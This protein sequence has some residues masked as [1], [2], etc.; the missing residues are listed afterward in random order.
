[1]KCWVAPRDVMP[2]ELYADAIVHAMDTAKV[3]VL[4][5]SRSAATSP[6]VLR[7]VERATSKRHPVIALRI[8]AAPLASLEYFLNTSQWLD[9]RKGD[10][11]Y[12]SPKLVDAVQRHLDHSASSALRAQSI[13]ADRS[14][15]GVRSVLRR[16]WIVSGVVAVLSLALAYFIVDGISSLAA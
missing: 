8:D 16:R 1:M 11:A 15:S 14:D 13:V 5:L 4:V 6:H 3:V 7:E 2:G 9:A 12:A 10:V